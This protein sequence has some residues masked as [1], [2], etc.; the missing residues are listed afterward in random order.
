MKQLSYKNKRQIKM[1]VSAIVGISVC[2]GFMTTLTF[3]MIIEAPIAAVAGVMGFFISLISIK[4]EKPTYLM[5]PKNTELL[6]QAVDNLELLKTNSQSFR[7]MSVRIKLQNVYALMSELFELVQDSPHKVFSSR[8]YLGYYLEQCNTMVQHYT[9][10]KLAKNRSE[11]AAKIEKNLDKIGQA[12]ITHIEQIKNEE[13][14]DLDLDLR[15]L[16]QDLGKKGIK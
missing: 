9:A 14:F 11:M 6:A 10:I 2:A 7:V 1:L 8:D 16:E 5:Q 13:V 12:L 3:P 4:L 15:V